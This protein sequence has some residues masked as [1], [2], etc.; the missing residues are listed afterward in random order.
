MAIRVVLPLP[1]G[2]TMAQAL[3]ASTANEISSRTVSVCAPLL[4]SLV[5]CSTLR[6]M[7]LFMVDGERGKR[8]SGMEFGKTEESLNASRV[9]CL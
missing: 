4:K 8:S 9:E 6:I 1:E 3:P 7:F 5:K 2:P